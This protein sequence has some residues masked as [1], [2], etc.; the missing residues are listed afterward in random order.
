MNWNE[1]RLDKNVE[2]EML[3]TFSFVYVADY[4]S[5]T[6]QIVLDSLWVK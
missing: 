2:V 6:F 1:K 5:E 4:V 3:D